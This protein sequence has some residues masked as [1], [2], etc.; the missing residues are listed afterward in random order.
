M[1]SDLCFFEF[2]EMFLRLLHHFHVE[3]V[4]LLQI[5]DMVALHLHV[6]LRVKKQHFLQDFQGSR[7]EE[8]EVNKQDFFYKSFK[9]AE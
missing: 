6:L 3:G 7:I 5:V 8:I 1:F 9:V 4:R 2:R